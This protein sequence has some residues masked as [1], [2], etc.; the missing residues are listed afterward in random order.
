MLAYENVDILLIAFCVV[1]R[2]SFDNV[3][4]VWYKEVQDNKKN[5]KFENT[6]VKTNLYFT[7]TKIC[8]DSAYTDN[9]LVLG[10]A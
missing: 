6:K 9:H 10:V 2:P 3:K 5:H 1:A 7:K 8:S 4:S